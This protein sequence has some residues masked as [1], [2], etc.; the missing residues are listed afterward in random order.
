[1]Q[2]KELKIQESVT[3]ELYARAS[4]VG[5]G[6]R[7]LAIQALG[8][9]KPSEGAQRT[10]E[11][12]GS[13]TH[14]ELRDDINSPTTIDFQQ[15]PPVLREEAEVSISMK[16]DA[17]HN[18]SVGAKS[19]PVSYAPEMR[20][21]EDKGDVKMMETS[22]LE[23]IQETADPVRVEPKSAMPWTSPEPK[24]RPIA[25]FGPT[26]KLSKSSR[27]RK[28]P[29][30][31]LSRLASYGS[32]AA[33]I[34]M[35]TLA[36]VTRRALGFKKPEESNK[37]S[38]LS[39]SPILTEANAERIVDT[40]CRVRGAAL[41]LGQ[42]LSIQDNSF[43]NPQ[44]QQVFERVRQSA[45]F[46]PVRQMERVLIHEMGPDWR[47]KIA[48]FQEKP[49]AAASIGQVHLATLHDGRNVAMKIQYPGVAKGIESD[50]NNLVSVMRVWDIFP[51]GLYLDSI[52][53]V[54]KRELAWEVDYIRE[55]KCTKRMRQY[56][57]PYP[58][59]YVP[60]VIDELTT[61]QLYTTE[62]L[63]GIPVDKWVDHDQDTR[64]RIA[65]LVI[66]L[67]MLELFRF[68]FMQ[69][70]PN[71]ANFL[72]NA[73]T[74]QLGLLDFGASRD[75]SHEFVSNYIQVIRGAADR[76]KGKILEKSREL[77]FLTGYESPI[78]ENAHCEAVMVLGEAFTAE[79]EY[80]FGQQNVTPRIQ[81]LVQVM[82]E[83]RL[84]P[85]PE[86][87]YSL[88]RKLAGV[89]LLCAKLR[90]KVHCKD[91]F[92]TSWE[93]YQTVDHEHIGTDAS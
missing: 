90:A 22:L 82:L 72:Y 25:K 36:E 85:P 64:N 33:G 68:K 45:D 10:L 23:V 88:H 26:T 51:R 15:V 43:I 58:D 9:Q 75:F 74:K 7:Q 54:A 84:C 46:M 87:V 44:L 31:R 14:E 3:H 17:Q 35:G 38:F 93:M 53:A 2:R 6:A 77:G 66:R 78:M 24:K 4:M 63:E 62:L 30:S 47:S 83:H 32:L 55:A 41:K 18:V 12:P 70:D 21:L 59:Y 76:D 81:R 80:D 61:Q 19:S 11:M 37:S 8:R 42:M 5:E 28:V 69:T 56:L 34:G 91:I 40:L 89:F 60:E 39:S 67:L 29:A 86:E 65:S 27:E 50:I 20:E 16:A 71:W 48:D 73:E 52:I 92:E 13:T 79:K 49:F 57:E 1:M